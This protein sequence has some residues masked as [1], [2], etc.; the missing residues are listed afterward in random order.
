[1]DAG[2]VWIEVWDAGCGIEQDDLD[3]LFK[4]FDTTK[5]K[6][7]MGIGAYESRHIIAAM[8]G[9]LFV[10]SEPGAGTTFTIV[11]PLAAEP[12][13]AAGVATGEG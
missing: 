4:P 1:M 12:R 9:E 10:E 11:L 3:R 13:A 8:N 7:G 6:A 5:G 2:W